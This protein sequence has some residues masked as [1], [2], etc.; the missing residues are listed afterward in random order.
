MWQGVITPPPEVSCQRREGHKTTT[1]TKVLKLTYH[2]LYSLAVMTS[3]DMMTMMVQLLAVMMMMMVTM[4]LE[5]VAVALGA[6]H[7]P[8]VQRVLTY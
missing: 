6:G 2:S 3:R 5:V 1:F 7:L 4:T 8:L